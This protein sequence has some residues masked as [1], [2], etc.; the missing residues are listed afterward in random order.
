VLTLATRLHWRTVTCRKIFQVFRSFVIAYN[1]QYVCILFDTLIM[2]DNL[3]RI[4]GKIYL[5]SGKTHLHQGEAVKQTFANV[6]PPLYASISSNTIFS[7]SFILTQV[8]FISIKTTKGS[9]NCHDLNTWNIFR[10]VTV[11]Q[12]N[13]V[14]KVNT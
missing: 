1:L 13:L 11:R 2:S 12:C 14:A 3:T 4:Q 8:K 5:T 7:I 9:R 6:K 10:Q